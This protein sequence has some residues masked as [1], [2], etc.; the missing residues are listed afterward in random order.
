M[1]HATWRVHWSPRVHRAASSAQAR[2]LPLCEEGG[3]QHRLPGERIYGH[4]AAPAP[5]QAAPQHGGGRRGGRRRARTRSGTCMAAVA[6]AL[7]HKHAHGSC[8]R[9]PCTACARRPCTACASHAAAVRHAATSTGR[10][11]PGCEQAHT[12]TLQQGF[13]PAL[14]L[15]AWASCMRNKGFVSGW[16]WCI[17]VVRSSN[18]GSMMLASAPALGSSATR[19]C[20]R[21]QALH[22]T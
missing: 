17:D 14:S 15:I 20:G 6:C 1:L 18:R 12:P 9:R 5:V 11:C 13:P 16:F 7:G 8:A 2:A 4:A 10:S 22:G 19:G 3:A 21:T